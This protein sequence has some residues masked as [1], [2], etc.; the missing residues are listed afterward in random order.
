MFDGT[1]HH[2]IR[3]RKNDSYWVIQR[4]P[5]SW[6]KDQFWYDWEGCQNRFRQ[7]DPRWSYELNKIY[8]VNPKVGT[9]QVD[10]DG[11]GLEPLYLNDISRTY[12]VDPNYFVKNQNKLK[13]NSI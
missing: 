1:K 12:L 4:L 8:Y 7:I 13:I 3:P 5:S 9:F 11:N 2:Y 6:V 10:P